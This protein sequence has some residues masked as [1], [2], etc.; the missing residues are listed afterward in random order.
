MLFNPKHETTLDR[1]ANELRHARAPSVDLFSKVARNACTRN[2]CTRNACI[3]L[4]LLNKAGKTTRLDRL[5]EAEAW[6]DAALALIEM[7]LPEWK[8]RRL[9]YD[10]GEWIC[11]LSSQPS[12][13]AQI[14][15]TADA[16]HEVLAIAL[17]VAFIEACRRNSESAISPA[18]VSL[19]K[20][21]PAF[22]ICC[23]NFS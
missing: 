12:L 11:C 6:T 23:D 14:D 15:D 20:P 4:P 22:A 2:A 5:I 7:E 1:L 9:A 18:A 17:L 10:D 13:P 3:R 16:N 19:A 8:L 21:A